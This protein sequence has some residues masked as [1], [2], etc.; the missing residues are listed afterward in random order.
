[1][2]RSIG[3]M[4]LA[5]AL[6]NPASADQ[7]QAGF[8]VGVTVPVRVTLE[9][10]EQPTQLALTDED[11]ARGYKDVSARYRVRYND[12][13]GYLLRLAPRLGVTQ[14]VEVRGLGGNIVLREAAIDISRA[15]AAFLQDLALEFHFV[16]DPS[17]SPGIVE[18]PVHVAATPI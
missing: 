6:A 1:M 18:L 17:A 15:G 3:A 10:V 11:V 13:R 7:R 9:V 5:A 8:Q 14:Y 2:L 4:M 12:R 16:L